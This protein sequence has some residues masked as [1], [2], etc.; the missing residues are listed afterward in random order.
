[1]ANVHIIVEFHQAALGNEGIN[2][3]F[4]ADKKEQF[5]KV[6]LVCILGEIPEDQ[7]LVGMTEMCKTL[8]P[9]DVTLPITEI[10]CDPHFQ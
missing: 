4:V 5:D 6:L 10:V 9:G 1:M 8:E 7:C 2:G 3:A